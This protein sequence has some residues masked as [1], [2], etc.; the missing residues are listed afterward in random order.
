MEFLAVGCAQNLFHR[1]WYRVGKLVPVHV[2][3]TAVSHT[4][5][6]MSSAPIPTMQPHIWAMH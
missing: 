3:C 2:F 1:I 6:N 5:Q 4:A